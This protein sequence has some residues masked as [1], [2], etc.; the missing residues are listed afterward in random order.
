M[1]KLVADG[2][3][4]RSLDLDVQ[5]IK[6]YGDFLKIKKATKGVKNHALGRGKS[7]R[8]RAVPFCSCS[9]H[10]DT[11]ESTWHSNLLLLTT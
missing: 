5:D 7:P 1:V 9:L 6:L 11:K 10:K 8:H 4:L 2:P 3:E